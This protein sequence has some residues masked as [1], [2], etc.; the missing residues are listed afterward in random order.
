MSGDAPQVVVIEGDLGGTI[1]A[2]VT[3]IA[4]MPPE[5]HWVLVGGFAVNLRIARVH[6][7]TGDIDTVTSAQERLVELIVD[8]PDA[9]RIDRAK[10][11]VEA[12]MKVKIDVMA[13]TVGEALPSGGWRR[14]FAH[15]RRWAMAGDESVSITVVGP[16]GSSVARGGCFIAAV[17][18]LVALKVVAIRGRQGRQSKTKVGSD[19]HDLVRLMARRSIREIAAGFATAPDELTQYVGRDLARLFDP[20]KDG[21]LQLR[22]LQMFSGSNVDVASIT[23]DDLAVLAELGEILSG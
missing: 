10:V 4:S 21:P 18:V 16:D 20:D 22:R 2:F 12:G 7:L 11:A 14:A 3:A 15:A 5:P 8:Q 23:L 1:V 6:R 9:E 13:S 19:I 17:P